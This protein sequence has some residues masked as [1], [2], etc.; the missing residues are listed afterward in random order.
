MQLG[1]Q[2]HS[3]LAQV[4][5]TPLNPSETTRIT[6]VTEP[7]VLKVSRH[8]RAV[9]YARCSVLA[10][11]RSR[12]SFSMFTSKVRKCP[13]ATVVATTTVAGAHALSLYTRLDKINDQW[14]SERILTPNERHISLIRAELAIKN[15]AITKSF[16]NQWATQVAN[17]RI[18][19]NLY[20]ISIRRLISYLL[21][22]IYLKAL[23]IFNNKQPKVSACLPAEFIINY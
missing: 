17:E 6:E 20:G 23:N 8:S 12:F 18:I 15:I 14:F 22:S 4:R 7:K 5:L 3:H 13:I 16:P 1:I 10:E 11:S 2:S 9:C 21:F 19:F